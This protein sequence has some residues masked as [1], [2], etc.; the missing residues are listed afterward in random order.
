MFRI[1]SAI[2][3]VCF[4][5][6]VD[7]FLCVVLLQVDPLDPLTWRLDCVEGQCPSC[8]SLPISLPDNAE[9]KSVTL[10][11]W[12][13]RKNPVNKK[14]IYGLYSEQKSVAQCAEML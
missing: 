3:A 7:I 9:Q 12:S 14:M 6:A 10:S 4:S 2:S 13:K 5:S 11:Q 8:G 1:K